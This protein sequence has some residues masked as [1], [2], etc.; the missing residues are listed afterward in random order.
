M[1]SESQQSE[2]E[3]WL[4]ARGVPHLVAD[5]TSAD[6]IWT[7][8]RPYLIIA[9]VLQIFLSFGDRFTGWVQALMFVLGLAIVGSA[10]AAL[11]RWRR[12]DPF[13]TR[14]GVGWEQLAFFVVV[15]TV[16]RALSGTDVLRTMAVVAAANVLLLIAVYVVVG[17]GLIPL[18]RWAVGSLSGHLLALSR[19]LARTLP[20]VLV[21]TVFMFINA[22]IWQVALLAHW[23]AVAVAC[24]ALAVI[25]T[26][27]VAMSADDVVEAAQAAILVEDEAAA[28]CLDGT[29]L[30]GR[31]PS[32]EP[33]DLDL[34]ARVNLRL[35][36]VF[37]I[38]VQ[39]VLVASLIG[40]TYVGFGLL[41]VPFDVLELWGGVGADYTVLAETEFFGFLLTLTAEHLAVA[42]LV[43]MMSGLS[44]AASAITDDA[45]AR[46]FTVRLREELGQSLMVARTYRAALSP[47]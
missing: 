9:F 14:G 23:T 1:L 35:V 4:L 3:R 21:L 31:V 18:T 37:S 33:L 42:A 13:D 22:E 15:P 7:R 5:Y 40:L 20:V 36:V 38:G 10:V 44:V 2:V 25:G 30:A 28:T 17:F 27:F 39:V 16:I 45:Y 32:T 19:L 43:A 29:P 34:G 46:T 26:V 41:L 47:R 24:G 11:R 8:A 12:V 6:R